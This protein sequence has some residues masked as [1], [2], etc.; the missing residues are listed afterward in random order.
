MTSAL[1]ALIF[2]CWTA[3][4]APRIV[5]KDVCIWEGQVGDGKEG[6]GW[7]PSHSSFGLNYMPRDKFAKI[8]ALDKLYSGELMM[9]F[10]ALNGIILI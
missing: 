7:M 6:K 10:I 5:Y 2:N 3:R 4:E 9:V 1:E 8:S